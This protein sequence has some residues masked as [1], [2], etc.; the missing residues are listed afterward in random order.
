MRAGL[1]VLRDLIDERRD[2][3]VGRAV[4]ARLDDQAGRS[5]TRAEARGGGSRPRRWTA[6]DFPHL[7]V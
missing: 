6:P 2:K 1:T 3:R 5:A 4:R 7:S